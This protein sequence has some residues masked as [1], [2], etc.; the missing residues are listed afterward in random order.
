ML[1]IVFIDICYIFMITYAGCFFKEDG[2]VWK[3]LREDVIIW[4]IR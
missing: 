1:Y 2:G 4:I 3:N